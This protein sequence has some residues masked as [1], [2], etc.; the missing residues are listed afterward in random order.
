MN[1]QE[2]I[3]SPSSIWILSY[4]Q[5]NEKT[6]KVVATGDFDSIYDL[7]RELGWWGFKWRDFEDA[8]CWGVYGVDENDGILKIEK[9]PDSM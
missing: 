8:N 5:D 7:A 4:S 9:H 1:E 2:L 6:W 3:K